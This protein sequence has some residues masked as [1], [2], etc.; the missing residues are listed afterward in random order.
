MLD[1]KSWAEKQWPS[2]LFFDPR[3]HKRVVNIALRVM[4]HP[5]ASIP[6]RFPLQKEVKGCYRFLNN[7][8][9][10]HQMLQREHYR[11]V[12]AEAAS[13]PGRVLFIQD[14]SE[15]IYNNLK[16]TDLGPTA[17]SS[18]NG[19]M[20]HSCLAVKFA[21]NQPQ[22][23]GLSGQKA[24][25]RK[26]KEQG[27][28]PKAQEEKESMVWQEMIDQIG[29]VPENCKWTTVGDRGAD[30]FP[31]IE[32][33]PQGW[34]CVVRSKHDRKILVNDMSVRLKKYVRALPSMGTTTHFLRARNSF[35]RQVT[36]RVSWAE[37]DMLPPEAHKEKDPIKGSY[38]RVWCEEDPK[39]EW[40]LFTRSPITS[41]EEA[42]EIVTIYKHRWLIEEYHKCLKTGCQ[43]EKVQLRTADRLLVLFGMLGVIATQLLQLKGI[44]RVKPDEPAVKY[45]DKLSLAV[46][47]NIYELKSPLTVKEFWR[48][49]A[50]LA[51][52]MGRKSDGNPGWQKIWEGWSQLRNM[53]RGVEIGRQLNISDFEK[54][55]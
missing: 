53:C 44:S 13:A 4:K 10:N 45:V 54:I 46:L 26:E 40:I 38:V 14:G 55:T 33:L 49:V 42:S 20:F 28:D 5:K 16:W 22:I 37:V 2:S 11:N 23:I 3:H 51:G 8:A 36:L 24:W 1:F 7:K 29:P 15:L 6:G 12:L 31:F 32:S 21:D 47:Q 18:G 19:I 27:A 9:V 39:I 17:D 35:S 43:I 34:D 50:M 41:F 30:I 52:F 48:R 25:I